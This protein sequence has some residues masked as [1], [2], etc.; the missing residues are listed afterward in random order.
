[1][2]GGLGTIVYVVIGAFVAASHHYLAHV[3]SVAR[4]ASAVVAILLWPAILL[5]V[6]IHIS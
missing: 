4:V 5:G 6:H 3:G 1:M 2:Q